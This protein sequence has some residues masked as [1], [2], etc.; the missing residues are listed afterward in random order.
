[1]AI[2]II[3]KYMTKNTCYIS[4]QRRQVK[5]LML[6][7]IGCAQPRAEVLINNYNSP[8]TG[9]VA[10]HGFIDGNT[11]QIFQ[12]LPWDY[13]AGHCGS[14][15]RGSANNTHIAIEMCEPGCIKYTGGASFTCS[16]PATAKAVA[17]RTYHSAVQLFAMLCKMYGLNPRADGVVISHSEGHSRGIASNHGDPEHLWRG[18][19]LGYTMDQFRADVSA[20]MK[21]LELKVGMKVRLI[22]PVA[23]RDSVSIRTQKAGY[24]KYKNLPSKTKK[25]CKRLAG[26]KAQLKSD[27]VVVIRDVVTSYDGNVWIEIKNGWLPVVVKGVCRVE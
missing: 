20:A 19:G 21:P 15:S 4:A 17:K 11:G 9:G 14:G 23:I 7:S 6:H 22:Q 16:D 3:K 13:R 24:V 2:S 26:G 5:G 10:V 1:M 8:D 12:T 18:L 25:K 27:N